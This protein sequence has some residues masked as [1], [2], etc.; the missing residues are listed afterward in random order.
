MVRILYLFPDTNLFIQCR[1]LEEIDWSAWV[2]FDEVHLIVSH[3]VLREIDNQKTRGN[4]RV[5]RRA[6]RTNS[7]FRD[8]IVGTEDYKLIQDAGP[9]VRLVVN[10]SWR[11]S[12]ELADQLDYGKPDDEIV[13][14]LHAFRKARPGDDARLLTHDSGPMAT[15]KML[16]LPYEPVPDDWLVPPESSDT[17]RE[18]N[19]LQAELDRLKKTEPQ[20]RLTCLDDYGK[21][22]DALH[23]AYTIYE[24]LTDD[25]LTQLMESL[26]RH[27]PLAT[28]FGS[29]DPAERVPPLGILGHNI[30]EIYTPSSDEEIAAYRDEKYPEWLRSCE[31]EL[32]HLHTALQGDALQT[33]FRF[34][35]VNEGSRPANDALITFKATGRIQICAP[36]R[37]EDEMREPIQLPPAPSVPHG[38]WTQSPAELFGHTSEVADLLRNFQRQ[39]DLMRSMLPGYALPIIPPIKQPILPSVPKRDPNAFYYKPELPEV[40]TASFSLECEQWRHSLNP[41][42]F[43]GD[44]HFDLNAGEISGALECVIQAENISDPVRKT[45]RI[46]ITVTQVSASERAKALIKTLATRSES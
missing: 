34:S 10:S 27:F 3:P 1:P 45:V 21:E 37:R 40:P 7:L 46:M 19:R 42:V 12:P 13:G 20:I 26:R 31:D 6:R 14:C 4:N 8:I 33:G 17:E 32:R 43:D 25:E 30:K 9:H 35:A 41:E 38:N 39:T 44:I 22:T 36:P 15:A 2:E 16:S 11:P 23:F 28:D 24:P 29:R 18:K 5:G